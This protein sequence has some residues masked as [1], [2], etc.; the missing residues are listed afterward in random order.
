MRPP[1]PIPK[2]PPTLAR[3][4]ART[5]VA[6]RSRSGHPLLSS[7]VAA[8]TPSSTTTPPLPSLGRRRWLP[9]Q[10]RMAAPPSLT[11]SNRCPSL[12][13]HPAGAASLLQSASTPSSRS[14]LTLVFVGP[15]TF[16]SDEHP[17]GMRPPLCSPLKPSTQTLANVIYLGFCARFRILFGGGSID[18]CV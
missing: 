12:H 2:T 6:P 15:S 4:H 5:P 10:D 3:D 16:A 11:R 18:Q 7:T 17:P 8:A 9:M 1:I 14:A 13:P